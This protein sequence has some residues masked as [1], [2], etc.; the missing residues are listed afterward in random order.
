MTKIKLT[1]EEATV[2]KNKHKITLEILMAALCWLSP[3]AQAALVNFVVSADDYASLTIG[4]S[5]IC[6]HDS[7]GSG[8]CTGSFNMTPGAWY[9]IAIDYKNRWGSNGLGLFWDQPEIDSGIWA[10]GVVPEAYLR[11]VAS[12]G[13]YISGLH[14]D[15]YSLGGAFQFAVEGEGPIAGG[16][17]DN[18]NTMYENKLG[19]WGG[20]YTFWGAFHEVLTGQIQIKGTAVSNVPEPA[21]L[22][23]MG[24]G[25]AGLGC[26]R[27][28]RKLPIRNEAPPSLFL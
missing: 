16:N 17:A 6:T 4:G 8:G 12:T 24:L 2:L 28:L 5:H 22:V 13:G 20:S 21:T 9:D 3:Q 27:R 10:A 26:G 19:L 7:Y 23:L 14:A 25:M 15:Y 11:S 1:A 18:V